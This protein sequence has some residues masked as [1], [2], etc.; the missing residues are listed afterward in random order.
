MGSGKQTLWLEPWGK[1]SFRVRMTGEAVMDGNDWALTEKVEECQ[2]EITVEE[3]DTTDPWYA[4]E[5]YAHYHSKGKVYTVKK[6]LDL[7]RTGNVIAVST[8]E[9]DIKVSFATSVA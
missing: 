5:E 9:L 8:K 3:I 7:P 1:N 6:S 2:A 4:T